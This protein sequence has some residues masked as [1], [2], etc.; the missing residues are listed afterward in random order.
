MGKQSWHFANTK[1][2]IIINFPNVTMLQP[3]STFI[4]VQVLCFKEQRSEGLCIGI[5]A[6]EGC[7]RG[8]HQATA[9][10]A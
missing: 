7:Y 10:S 6:G 5:S 2:Q 9:L 3:G 8:M 1:S 4:T